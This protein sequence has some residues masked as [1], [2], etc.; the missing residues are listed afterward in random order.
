MFLIKIIRYV[1]LVSILFIY[2]FGFSSYEISFTIKCYAYSTFLLIPLF[3][4]AMQLHTFHLFAFTNPFYHFLV[5]ARLL[6]NI[7]LKSSN[8]YTLTNF[9]KVRFIEWIWTRFSCNARKWFNRTITIV[10]I[11]V[12]NFCSWFTNFVLPIFSIGRI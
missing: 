8:K 6:V 9:T 5:F 7:P 12:Y 4:T 2:H 1:T 3:L 11:T 10:Q